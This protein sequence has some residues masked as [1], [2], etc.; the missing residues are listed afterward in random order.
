MRK[1]LFLFGQLNDDDVEWMLTAGARRFVPA[2]G[3]LIEQGVPVD[4]VFILLAFLRYGIRHRGG[5]TPEE[6]MTR[7]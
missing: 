7:T 2:G 1:V 6:T 5:E 3:V 4:A